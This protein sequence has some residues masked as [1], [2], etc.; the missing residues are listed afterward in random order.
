MARSVLMDEIILIACLLLG[1]PAQARDVNWVCTFS[2]VSGDGFHSLEKNLVLVAVRSDTITMIGDGVR[3][4][5]QGNWENPNQIAGLV[6]SGSVPRKIIVNQNLRAVSSRIGNPVKSLKTWT[7]EDTERPIA[8]GG[9][10]PDA[11][12]P[13]IT[14]T[15]PDQR[16]EAQNSLLCLKCTVSSAPLSVSLNS[17][18]QGTL[19][20]GWVGERNFNFDLAQGKFLEGM[21]A[22][23]AIS[24]TQIEINESSPAPDGTTMKFLTTFSRVT[25]TYTEVIIT[26]NGKWTH[27]RTGTCQK[28]ACPQTRF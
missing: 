6:S 1:T 5:I 3:E 9:Q 24:Q 13:P 22:S 12:I 23:V 18:G 28:T 15:R 8:I 27:S 25:G 10:V 14:P 21:S 4:E 16:A 11:P 26:G 20:W 19:H 7:C 17:N 2:S